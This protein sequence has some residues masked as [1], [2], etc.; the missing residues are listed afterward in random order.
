RRGAGRGPGAGSDRT[1]RIGGM[2][3]ET[4]DNMRR[5][6]G[7]VADRMNVGD[8][9]RTGVTELGP[10]IPGLREEAEIFRAVHPRSRPLPEHGRLDQAMLA[11]LQP[12]QQ[13]IGALGLLGRALDDTANQKE[14][15]IVAAMKFG[16]D[17]FHSNPPFTVR[18]RRGA[19]GIRIGPECIAPACRAAQAGY[20]AISGMIFRRSATS[21]L[22]PAAA[23]AIDLLTHDRDGLLI[24][25][26]GIPCLDSGEVRLTRL[27]ARTGLPAM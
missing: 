9:F 19:S 2:P 17:G 10:V 24:N 16:I 5:V 26:R 12:G 21:A 20:V 14:L 1:G 8:H 11:C 27:I 22:R 23:P 25:F 13:P 15:R 7:G 3:T 18:T 6:S 4:S